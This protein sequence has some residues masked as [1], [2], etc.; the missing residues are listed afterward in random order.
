MRD[1]T[2][3]AIWR[4]LPIVIAVVGAAAVV[5]GMGLANPV[6]HLAVNTDRLGPDSGESVAHYQARARQSLVTDN[7]DPHWALVSFDTGQGSAQAAAAASGARISKALFQVQLPRVQTPVVAVQT[8][9]GDP[10]GQLD[11]AGGVAADQ[12]RAALADS[13]RAQRVDDYSAAQL[14]SDCACIIGLLVRAPVPVLARIQ[15]VPGVRAVEALPAD[16][17]YGHFSLVPL[18]PAQTDYVVPLPDDGPV[19]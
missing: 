5:V 14:Q 16:A 13:D 3:A 11:T 15:A 8:A 6:R 4:W 18:L 17:V 10:V 9:A 12:V 2:R 19:P 7:A 1:R